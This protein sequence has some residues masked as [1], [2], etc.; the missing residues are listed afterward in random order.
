MKIQT[1]KIDVMDSLRD[2]ELI[3]EYGL[4]EDCVFCQADFAWSDW[5]KWQCPET[6]HKFTGRFERVISCPHCVIWELEGWEDDELG[7]PGLGEVIEKGKKDPFEIE[8]LDPE[9]RKARADVLAST[10]SVKGSLLSLLGEREILCAETLRVSG[11]AHLIGRLGIY[12]D[13]K[14]AEA[15]DEPPLWSQLPSPKSRKVEERAMQVRD[16]VNKKCKIIMEKL[17][18]SL[19]L[20]RGPGVFIGNK[21]GPG[22][23]IDFQQQVWGSIMSV[24]EC[25]AAREALPE[26]QAIDVYTK[27]IADLY[28]S[29]RIAVKALGKW[30]LFNLEEGT[31]EGTFEGLLIE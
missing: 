14:V 15:Y 6:G 23:K 19:S 29:Q 16:L 26:N 4:C 25:L 28:V 1:L 9:M 8:Q 18:L 2:I 7:C 12:V 31:E 11:Y 3:E 5:R 10:L 24:A 13:L 21:T 20:D 27:P 17:W 30:Y 22:W